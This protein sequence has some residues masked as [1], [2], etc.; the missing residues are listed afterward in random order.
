L[1]QVPQYAVAGASFT[2]GIH[3]EGQ[4]S[5]TARRL[6]KAMYDHGVLCHSVSV[7]EPTVLKFLPPLI[8]SE[9][10]RQG[11]ACALES[12]GKDLLSPCR[13][14]VNMTWL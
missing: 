3:G 10:Q 1:P 2:A 13:A 8:L 14:P 4:R 12:G 11:I 6:Y 7:I 5:E 9:D